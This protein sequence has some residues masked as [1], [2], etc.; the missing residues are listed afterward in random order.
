MG[1]LF[2]CCSFISFAQQTQR[3]SLTEAIQVALQNNPTI[4]TAQKEIVVA[5]SR[6]LQAGKI[7]NPELSV[8]W[9]EVPS[10]F[11]TANERDVSLSQQLEF[12]GKRS[13]RIN[14]AMSEKEIASLEI[15]RRIIILTSR[16]KIAYFNVLFQQQLVENIQEQI[17]LLT[18]F[19][20]TI[21]AQY[22]S[23]K[24]N[25]LDVIRAN[26]ELTRIGNDFIEAK[27]ELV[28]RQKELIL[29]LGKE[30]DVVIEPS[31]SLLYIPFSFTC[32][33]I[34]SQVMEKSFTAKLAN[35]TITRQQNIVSLAQKNYYPD[36][37]IGISQQRR[38]GF[39]SFPK[40]YFGIELKF[41]L[42]FWF[43]QEP[44]GQEQE[45]IALVD[46]STINAQSI[47]RRI[48]ANISKAYDAVVVSDSQVK[49]FQSSLRRDVNEILR[50][51]ISQYGNNQLDVL[52]LLDIYRTYRAANVEYAR[53]L[54][55]YNIALAELESAGELSINE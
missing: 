25:Y 31:D 32:E 55:N 44:K 7:S 19:Q 16:V 14:I 5:D 24:S 6:I 18:D 39:G 12:P 22:Q 46:I 21:T 3:I 1:I 42:P 54:L 52:N 28:I 30:S 43:W 47:Q 4:L 17:Q 34:F 36:Y 20:Q 27:R 37:E 49:V 23:G 15:E 13:G 10:L 48:S 2:L 8:G 50:A 41:S 38:D 29:F 40:S 33:T 53:A 45:A 11:H 9:N 51:G 35:T 26:V